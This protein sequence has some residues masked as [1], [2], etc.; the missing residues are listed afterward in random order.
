LRR[1]ASLSSIVRGGERKSMLGA[2]VGPTGRD[3]ITPET[4]SK[5]SG[6]RDHELLGG[7]RAKDLGQHGNSISRGRR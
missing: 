1:A 4:P 3:E 6:V 7:G 5:L 2:S